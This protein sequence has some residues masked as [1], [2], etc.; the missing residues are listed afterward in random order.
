MCLYGSS[1]RLHWRL[2]I[3][4]MLCM[5]VAVLPLYLFYTL[6]RSWQPRWSAA[7]AVATT[8]AL[9]AVFLYCFWYIGDAFP[10]T[11]SKH[12]PAPP[13]ASHRLVHGQVP[14]KRRAAAWA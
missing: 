10:I 4:V 3:L 14:D 2:D 7:V 6:V 5:V 12:G 11:S 13:A 1:R 9:W 8:L